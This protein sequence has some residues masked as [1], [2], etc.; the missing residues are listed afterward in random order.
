MSDSDA[1]N[2]S[3]NTKTVRSSKDIKAGLL[4]ELWMTE[5]AAEKISQIL[6]YHAKSD[7]LPEGHQSSVYATIPHQDPALMRKNWRNYLDGYGAQFSATDYVPDPERA[8]TAASLKDDG[9]IKNTEIYKIYQ[10]IVQAEK[11]NPLDSPE[12]LLKHADMLMM[13]SPYEAAA[14]GIRVYVENA[15]EA[16]YIDA[17]QDAED[18]PPLNFPNAVTNADLDY[19]ARPDIHDAY[20]DDSYEVRND[21]DKLYERI[22][23]ASADEGSIKPP[24]SIPDISALFNDRS[25][26]DYSAQTSVQA[27]YQDDIYAGKPNTSDIILKSK[28]SED[29]NDPAKT[30]LDYEGC[31]DVHTP[32]AD[33]FFDVARWPEFAPESTE[34]EHVRQK[35]Q[36]TYDGVNFIVAKPKLQ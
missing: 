7:A 24:P 34:L 4:K 15:P 31:N 22:F 19:N 5:G 18:A 25:Q 12:L 32:Y 26:L 6:S 8:A 35:M 33:R 14:Q 27:S 36:E 23:N 3:L 2:D 1:K 29:S 11:E 16:L 10:E 17:T 28:A 21:P 13:K 30:M 20:M 9:H